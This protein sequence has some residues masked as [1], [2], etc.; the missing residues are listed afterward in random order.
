[1]FYWKENGEQ[2]LLTEVDGADLLSFLD[3][4]FVAADLFYNIKNNLI[5]DL[6]HLML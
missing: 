4:L 1:M 2:L 5:D 3:L 6:N